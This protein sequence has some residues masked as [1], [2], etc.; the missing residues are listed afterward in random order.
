M[1][2][3]K[4]LIRVLAFGIG[5]TLPAQLTS[6]TDDERYPIKSEEAQSAVAKTIRSINADFLA[7]QKI[8]N[9]GVLV[10]FNRRFLDNL[11]YRFQWVNQRSGKN[12]IN[13]AFLS[14]VPIGEVTIYRFDRFT[15]PGETGSWS[16]VRDLVLVTLE[17]REAMTL[18]LLMVHFKAPSGAPDDDPKSAKWRLAEA[19]QVHTRVAALLKDDPS[20]WIAVIG[21]VNDVPVSLAYRALTRPEDGIALIDVHSSLPSGQRTTLLRQSNYQIVEPGQP[22][23]YI[24]VSPTLAR[25]LVLESASA[26][27]PTESKASDHSPLVASFDLPMPAP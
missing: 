6:Y 16:F 25:H 9:Q 21:D 10:D 20:A 26:P 11:G 15:L 3:K 8:E 27:L 4:N 17:P 2:R 5:A 18:K 24:L 7:L 22:V 13:L 23:D 12:A 19:R 1:L 14:R